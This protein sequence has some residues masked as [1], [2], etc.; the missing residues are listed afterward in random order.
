M[1]PTPTNVFTGFLGV[2]KTTAILDLLRRKPAGGRWAVLVNEYGEVGIDEAV[3]AGAGPEGV[4]V[5]EVGGGCVCCATAPYLPVA[6]HFLLVDAA[7]AGAVFNAGRGE[8]VRV[9]D[10]LDGLVRLARVPVD[11]RSKPDP[12]RAGDT[13]VVRAD[14]SALRAATGWE[15]RFALADTLADTL[16]YWRGVAGRA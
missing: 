5:R 1:P 14:S 15:P 9:R 16:A 12:T 10:L 11:V 4:T 7:P 8:P 13:A 6:L 3:I 2:G